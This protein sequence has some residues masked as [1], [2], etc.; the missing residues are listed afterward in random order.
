MVNMSMLASLAGMMF[1]ARSTASG[2]FDGVGWE[3]DAIAAVFIGGAAV[4]GGVGTVIGSMVGGLV[5]AVLN[6]G[7]QLLGAGADW[8][9]MIKGLVL[10]LAVAVDVWNKSQGRPS[11]VGL[12]T[13]KRRDTDDTPPPT[14]EPAPVRDVT[15]S[16]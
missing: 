6:N 14:E 2:P 1:V 13:R 9:Q 16:I 8:T 10:L 11:I 5:M 15:T 4:S 12:F 3:L 7:L